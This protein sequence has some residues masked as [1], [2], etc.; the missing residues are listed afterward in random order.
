MD[1]LIQIDRGQ[2]S[3]DFES[4]FAAR[5]P[6]TTI[7]K[8]SEQLKT[9]ALAAASSYPANG[10][11]ASLVIYTKCQCVIK[12]GKTFDGSAWGIA[13]PGGGALIGDVY[14]DN[15]DALYARTTSFALV[16]TPV[17]TSFIFTDDDANVLGS[18]QAGAVSTVA[19]SG[20]GRGSWS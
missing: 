19:G 16:A 4:A 7:S 15:L 6:D 3:R 12:G 9:V 18:F 11:V 14:T 5:L 20:G 2:I 1:S 13:L 8:M 17:Y 10:S